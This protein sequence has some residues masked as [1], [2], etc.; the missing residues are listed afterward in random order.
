MNT[1]NINKIIVSGE[2]IFMICLMTLSL[3][4]NNQCLIIRLFCN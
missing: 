1:Q 2:L 3:A 4:Q